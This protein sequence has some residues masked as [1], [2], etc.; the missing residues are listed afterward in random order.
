MCVGVIS[1]S[2]VWCDIC[3]CVGCD[4][5][6]CVGCDICR[7]VGVISLCVLYDICVVLHAGCGICKVCWCDICVVLV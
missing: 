4:I 6:R 5:C 2:V 1:M 3:G 7:C